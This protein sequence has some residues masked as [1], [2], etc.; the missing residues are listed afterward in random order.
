MFR[1]V[2]IESVVNLIFSLTSFA[3]ILLSGKDLVMSWAD[4]CHWSTVRI[5]GGGCFGLNGA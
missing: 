1:K 2:V 4:F 5:I 3:E